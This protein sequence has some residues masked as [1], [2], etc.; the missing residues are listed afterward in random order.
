MATRSDYPHLAGYDAAY[1]I[2]A[3]YPEIMECGS[4]PSWI[5]EKTI[6]SL[7]FSRYSNRVFKQRLC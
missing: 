4:V 6:Y 2:F 3:P 1:K 5:R 7:G